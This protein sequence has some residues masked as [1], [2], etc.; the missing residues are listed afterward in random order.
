MK[1]IFLDCG[2]HLCEGLEKFIG[3]NIITSEFEIHTFEANP[4]CRIDER[5]K[6]LPYKIITHNKAVWINDGKIW[7]N[8]ENHIKSG[9]GSPTDGKSL[10]D[11]LGSSIDGIGFIHP[12]YENKIEVECISLSNFIKNLP[13]NS[14]IICKMDIEGSEFEVLRDMIKQGTITRIKD[15]YVEFHERF[16][17]NE[18]IDSK[19]LLINEIKSFGINVNTWV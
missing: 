1:K 6:L 11:G 17:P 13:D 5:I 15:L 14:E 8:Q 4:E 9:T 7:F 3:E 12:G 16:M 10:I 19:N 18:S 2:T